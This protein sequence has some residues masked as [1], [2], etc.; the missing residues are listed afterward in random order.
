MDAQ[1]RYYFH[2][3]P[4]SLEDGQWARMVKDLEWIRREEAKSNKIK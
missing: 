1:L 2:I 3:N 4:D